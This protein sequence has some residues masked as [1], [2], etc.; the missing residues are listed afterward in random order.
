[1][2][3]IRECHIVDLRY[4]NAKCVLTVAGDPLPVEMA[5]SKG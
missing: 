1:M 3:I 2:D 5:G 4:Q